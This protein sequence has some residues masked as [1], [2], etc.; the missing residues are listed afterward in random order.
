MIAGVVPGMVL[1]LMFVAYI[2]FSATPNPALTPPFEW[3]L[4]RLRKVS[5]SDLQASF[6]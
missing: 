4:H 5:E 1:T 2:I 6:A 3:P